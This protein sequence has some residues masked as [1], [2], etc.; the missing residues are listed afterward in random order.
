MLDTFAKRLASQ[1]VPS[2]GDL[3]VNDRWAIGGAFKPAIASG[4]ALVVSLGALTAAFAGTFVAPTADYDVGDR[5]RIERRP[6]PGDLGLKNRFAIGG[7][8]YAIE[9]TNDRTGK[10]VATVG[11]LSSSLRGTAI[12]TPLFDYGDR[13]HI[14]RRPLP[15]VGIGIENRY[16]LGGSFYQLDAATSDGRIVAALGGLVAS[17]R[18]GALYSHF[19][20]VEY[21]VTPNFVVTDMPPSS[22]LIAV[23]LGGALASLRGS[24]LPPDSSSGRIHATLGVLTA[25]LRG[26][27]TPAAARDGRLHID[28]GSLTSLLRG[29]SVP[30][31]GV[32]GGINA[33]LGGLSSAFAGTFTPFTASGRVAAQ[34]GALTAQVFGQW[35]PAGAIVGR[36]DATTGGLVATFKGSSV[37]LVGK[38]DAL[39]LSVRPAL[40]GC[41]EIQPSLVAKLQVIPVK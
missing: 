31:Q 20:D 34:V 39:S 1:F 27:M 36:I 13:L 22:G 41:V 15:S 24:A 14:E 10:I 40:D 7:S 3:N 19:F 33:T 5:F 26:T 16:A 25:L 9:S 17:L 6:L 23:T 35:I 8:F 2:P 28:C 11:G 30:P 4:G 12:F 21:S 32:I 29:A 18:G 37:A 38:L